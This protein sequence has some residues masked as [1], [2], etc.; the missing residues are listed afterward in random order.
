M[1][2][3]LFIMI[4]GVLSI[5]FGLSL[6]VRRLAYPYRFLGISYLIVGYGSLLTILLMNN[7]ILQ[8][9]HLLLTASPFHYL[10]GPLNYFFVLFLLFPEKKWQK[11]YCLHLIPF[12]LHLVELLPFYLLPGEMK[13]EVYLMILD[14]KKA[15]NTLYYQMADGL[16]TYRVHLILKATQ[17]AVYSIAIFRLCQQVFCNNTIHL[18]NRNKL[19]LR[20]LTFDYTMKLTSNLMILG[21]LV[22][23]FSLSGVLQTT[24]LILFFIDSILGFVFFLFNPRLLQGLKWRSSFTTGV[25]PAVALNSD[26]ATGNTPEDPVLMEKEILIPAAEQAL[27]M[28]LDHYMQLEQLY[29]TN[30]VNLNQVARALAVP[31]YRLSKLLNQYYG[32]NFPEYVNSL[33]LSYIDERIKN[34]EK[35]R[36]YSFES[37]A[38]EAGFNS[39]NAFYHSFRK[40]RSTTPSNF[41]HQLNDLQDPSREVYQNNEIAVW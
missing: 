33:R 38:M 20:W 34:C 19:L 28:K 25:T 27:F 31:P 21:Y 4:A 1:T 3:E 35:F 26:S 32:L 2:T 29:L 15:N 39:K 30:K 36:N 16:F 12:A 24:G 22:F 37:M 14:P 8:Y 13:K 7:S 6:T 40:M 18:F 10:I 23:Y 17:S 5:L 11:Q 41:Y 9:P